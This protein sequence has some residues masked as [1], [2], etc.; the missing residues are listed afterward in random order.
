MRGLELDRESPSVVYENPSWSQGRSVSALGLGTRFDLPFGRATS[1]SRRPAPARGFPF[2]RA[3]MLRAN[4]R[5][6]RSTKCY[7]RDPDGEASRKSWARD[8]PRQSRPDQDAEHLAT[9]GD[10]RPQAKGRAL[11]TYERARSADGP[12][13]SPPSL[14][15]PM[16]NIDREHE[17]A[18]DMVDKQ[19]STAQRPTVASSV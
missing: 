13:D 6:G 12:R 19:C 7:R 5:N 1:R 15:A 17:T 16:T 2:C 14:P 8:G 9:Y 11:R 10:E 4:P 18:C 3:S